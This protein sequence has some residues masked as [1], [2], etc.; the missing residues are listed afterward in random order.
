MYVRKN[1]FVHAKR[2]NQHFMIETGAGWSEGNKGDW[3]V[4]VGGDL[5]LALSD[6]QFKKIYRPYRPEKDCIGPC[7]KE[8]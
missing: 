1:R 2:I 8:E 4:L 6:E 7:D 3:L 5:W